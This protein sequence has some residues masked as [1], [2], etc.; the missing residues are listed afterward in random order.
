MLRSREVYDETPAKTLGQEF[1]A[2]AQRLAERNVVDASACEDAL[3]QAREYRDSPLWCDRACES[4][5]AK[6]DRRVKETIESEAMLVGITTAISPSGPID[7]AIVCWRNARLVLKIAELYGV[8]P[9][10][11]GSIRLLRRV[12]T[13]MALAGLSQEFT[14]M[15]YA[16][17]GP[18]VA[19]AAVRGAAT[20]ADALAKMGSTTAV[21]GEPIGILLAAGGAAG[22]A[23]AGLFAT[24]GAQ[25]AGPMLQGVLNAILTL[26]IGLAAQAEC[27]LLPLS[28]E[29]RRT[30]AAGILSVIGALRDAILTRKRPV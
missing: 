16:V 13:N 6:V 20:A 10:S 27:R 8:R 15:L 21:L 22:K 19:G 1:G 7:V 25:L 9:G 2:F 24:A 5:Y 29:T 18:T 12:A 23:A 11:L 30:R 26:R 4:L 17:Y 3:L 28:P 14:Q